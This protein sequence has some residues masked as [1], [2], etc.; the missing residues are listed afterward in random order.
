MRSPAAAETANEVVSSVRVRVR[1]WVRWRRGEKIDYGIALSSAGLNSPANR[2]AGGP[3]LDKQP[4]A[5]RGHVPLTAS[6]VPFCGG[7]GRVCSVAHV[8]VPI[9]RGGADEPIA[10]R[11]PPR[12]SP[13]ALPLHRKERRHSWILVLIGGGA[14]LSG[15]SRATLLHGSIVALMS[16][17]RRTD[18]DLPRH[19]PRLPLLLLLSLPVTAAM[20]SRPVGA[21]A[22]LDPGNLCHRCV[23]GINLFLSCFERPATP[24]MAP[25]LSPQVLLTPRFG[26][27]TPA[28]PL[29][30]PF[31]AIPRIPFFARFRRAR[32]MPHVSLVGPRSYEFSWLCIRGRQESPV[33]QAPPPPSSLP[34]HASRRSRGP[35]RPRLM[36]HGSNW[37]DTLGRST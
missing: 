31:P 13:T 33:N 24:R 4:G 26:E 15:I 5:Q 32:E 35:G 22:V 30:K 9:R 7:A 34:T 29:L 8:V 17:G 12:R 25:E 28:R 37:H 27:P 10:V 6:G 3:Q 21:A 16:R 18:A 2:H 20:A 1:A 36:W 11:R 19:H 14:W 23:H